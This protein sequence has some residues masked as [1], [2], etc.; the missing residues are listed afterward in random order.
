MNNWKSG[1]EMQ[2]TLTGQSNTL[3]YAPQETK[4]V[5]MSKILWLRRTHNPSKPTTGHILSL[6]T[7]A[8]MLVYQII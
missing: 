4:L 5:L 2:E 8:L 6:S 3:I 7:G 1:N